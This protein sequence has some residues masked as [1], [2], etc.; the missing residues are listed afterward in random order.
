MSNGGWVSIH[1]DITEQKRTEEKIAYMAHHDALTGLP[2]RVFLR[3]Q[4]NR[5]LA[6]SGAAAPSR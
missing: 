6:Q 4:L 1:Q 5:Q 2:N 3:E